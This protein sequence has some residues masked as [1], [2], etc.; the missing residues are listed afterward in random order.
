ML[1]SIKL[2]DQVKTYTKIGQVAGE[3]TVHRKTLLFFKKSLPKIQEYQPKG[4][5]R[6]L[7]RIHL[8]ESLNA[9]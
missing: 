4:I 9:I 6:T 2:K 5:V 3:Q 8:S 1:K 7:V